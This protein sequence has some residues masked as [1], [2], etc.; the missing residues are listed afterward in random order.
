MKYI[1]PYIPILA[2]M[3]LALGTIFY[4]WKSKCPNED[5]VSAI[6]EVNVSAIDEVHVSTV[7]ENLSKSVAY[8]L[9][10]MAMG[11][12]TAINRIL[13]VKYE[14]VCGSQGTSYHAFRREDE[15]IPDTMY[16]TGF[17]DCDYIAMEVPQIEWKKEVKLDRPVE[18][19][20]PCRD[21]IDHLMSMCALM[22][23][24]FKCRNISDE[25]LIIQ[26]DGCLSSSLER[27]HI[28]MAPSPDF[29]MKCF[30]ATSKMDDYIKYM[31][32]TLQPKRIQGKMKGISPR[33]NA[34]EECI[35]KT[36]NE[37]VKIKVE[38]I[39]I[40]QTSYYFQYCKECIGSENDLLS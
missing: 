3:I 34:G 31:G 16:E 1:R 30:S 26:V 29:T 35:Y 25:E 12:G 9:V 15:I 36:W 24:Y 22:Q 6:D 5:N 13:S 23:K 7:V 2:I 40:N 39:L 38:E 11:G 14:R 10:N 28:N 19:H 37:D 27:F 33:K 8:G 32:K 17:E 4:N 18:L 21:P 20:I